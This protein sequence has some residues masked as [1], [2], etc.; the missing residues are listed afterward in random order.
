MDQ[1]GRTVAAGDFAEDGLA[2]RGGIGSHGGVPLGQP[3]P[4]PPPP[5]T[6]DDPVQ[7]QPATG[8]HHDYIAGPVEG[9]GLV[10]SDPGAIRH[11][12]FHAMAPDANTDGLGAGEV[13]E[14]R[15][16]VSGVR[17]VLSHVYGFWRGVL[18]SAQ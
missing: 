8:S 16:Q 4:A 9:G 2:G 10:H 6:A 1:A 5:V 13:T 15:Q 11:Q 18:D 3:A 12:R 17:G 7:G 14:E